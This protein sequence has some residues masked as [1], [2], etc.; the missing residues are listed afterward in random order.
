MQSDD[1]GG[2]T[3][4]PGWAGDEAALPGTW[5]ELLRLLRRGRRRWLRTVVWSLLLAAAVAA[6]AAQLPRVYRSRALVRVDAGAVVPGDVGRAVLS[7]AQLGAVVVA[8]GLYPR[9]RG[10][11][12]AIAAMR[13]DLDVTLDGQRLA[14][15]WRGD[16]AERVF[17]VVRDLGQIVADEQRWVLADPGH[18]DRGLDRPTRLLAVGLVSFFVGLPLVGLGVGAFDRRIYDADD[19]RRLGM[20]TI[21]TVRGFEGDNAGALVARLTSRDR[22]GS[23]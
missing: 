9:A 11:K 14:I 7:D 4:R 16:D 22:M 10:Q 21:G 8:H 3:V 6:L 19:V 2:T 12:E 5:A 18:A 1:T 23:S 17:Q 15:S 13:A 20:M